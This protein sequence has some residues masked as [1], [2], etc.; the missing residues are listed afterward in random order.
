[1]DPLTDPEAIKAAYDALSDDV[2][3]GL[4]WKLVKQNKSWAV[5]RAAIKAHLNSHGSLSLKDARDLQL[6]PN[7][8]PSRVFVGCII[9]P[10]NK[11]GYTIKEQL[12]ALPRKA[13]LYHTPGNAV[14][15]TTSVFDEPCNEAAILV[16]TKYINGFTGS[17]KVLKDIEASKQFPFMKVNTKRKKFNK[18]IINNLPRGCDGTERPFVYYNEVKR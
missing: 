7:N 4:D 15:V 18:L 5:E 2:K 8:T 3:Q 6:V 17:I 16:V 13:I 12:G 9:N 1:M 11:E 10:L 14:T